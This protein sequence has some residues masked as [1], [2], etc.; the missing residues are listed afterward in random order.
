MDR[1]VTLTLTQHLA[2]EA[3]MKQ[4]TFVTLSIVAALAAMPRQ[5]KKMEGPGGGY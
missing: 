4:K 3:N 1:W 5:H 2:K